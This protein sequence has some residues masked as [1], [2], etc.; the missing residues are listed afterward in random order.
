MTGS[1]EAP[2]GSREHWHTQLYRATGDDVGVE[3]PIFTGDVFDEIEIALPGAKTKPRRLIVLTHPCSMRVDGV[4]LQKRLLVAVVQDRAI[5]TT[6]WPAD[7]HYDLMPLPDLTSPDSNEA[8][9]FLNVAI[10]E[11]KNLDAAKR[12]ATLELAGLNL[13]QQRFVH[14]LT[15]VVVPTVDI[16]E[17]TLPL[18]EEVDIVEDWIMTAAGRNLTMAEAA[19]ECHNWL[20][21]EDGGLTRQALLSDPQSRSRIRR[22]A[23]IAATDGI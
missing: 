19:E 6:D 15:R 21:T 2:G 16:A 4:N 23:S 5:A 12:I 3:R 13:M 1:L 7:G 22:E 17:A 14:Q 9:D 10:V 18:F 20:R 11:S 8:A